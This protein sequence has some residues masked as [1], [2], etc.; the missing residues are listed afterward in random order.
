MN[1]CLYCGEE[2]KNKYCSVVCQNKHQN[3]EKTIKKYGEFMNFNVSCDACG[4]NFLVNEREF[5]FPQKEKYFCSRSCSNKRI[6][7]IEKRI[8]LSK[9]NSIVKIINCEFC[10]SSFKQIKTTQRFCSR[11]CATKHRKPLLGLG[12]VGGLASVKSQNRRSKNEILFGD[13]CLT[14]FKNVLFNEQMF[15]GWDADII[16]LDHKI[17]ILWNGVWHYKKI[18]K[19][20][21]LKQ[22]QNRDKIKINEIKKMGFEPY[23]IKDLGKFNESLVIDEF[24]K[25]KKYIAVW[26]NGISPVS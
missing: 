20:H 24:E 22:V 15:N 26:R 4:N 11:S 5:L 21:S 14:E 12:N 2:V 9:E 16:L 13:I 7:S 19:A 8:K 18:T 3:H 25:L 1:T 17:A 23:I 10:N 6:M